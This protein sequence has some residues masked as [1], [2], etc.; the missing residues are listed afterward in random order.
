MLA[1]IGYR[2]FP[3]FYS[4]EGRI[5]RRVPEYFLEYV[6]GI[7]EKEV[8]AIGSLPNLKLRRR[9]VIG[10]QVINPSFERRKETLAKKIYVYPEK[11]GEETVRNVYSIG[12]VLKGPRFP[13]FL[14]ILYIFPI[15]LSSNSIVGKGLEGMMELLEELGVEVTLGTK[16]QGRTTLE[17][18][19]PEAESDYTVLVDDFGRVIDTSL[20]FHSDE[21]L[22]L[23]ELVLLYR[24]RRGSR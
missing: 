8:I 11:K 22:Y 1:L 5:T 7:R 19:D 16:S 6:S 13:V 23:F 18:H 12:L 15:R 9:V 14:P 24:N 2:K 17:V 10:D 4:K 20:C 21:S 3:I